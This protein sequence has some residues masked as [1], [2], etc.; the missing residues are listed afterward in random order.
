LPAAFPLSFPP[1]FFAASSSSF[2]FL[3]ASSANFLILSSSSFFFLSSSSLALLAASSS[4]ISFLL[5]FFSFPV[6][7]L[8][9]VITAAAY[10][11]YSG[12]VSNLS[13]FL[14]RTAYSFLNYAISLLKN[15]SL[16]TNFY[17]I[18]L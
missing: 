2:L 5:F 1:F 6:P 13:S 17:F 7:F 4:S 8:L 18:S 3:S 14:S 10:L 15:S 11:T 16:S 12:G 9:F